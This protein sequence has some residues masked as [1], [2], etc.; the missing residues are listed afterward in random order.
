MKKILITGGAGYIGSKLTTKLLELNYQVTVVDT[1]NYTS[2][3]LNHLYNNKNFIFI[4]DDVRNKRLIKR[5]IKKNEFIIPLAALVG[6]P[7]CEENRKDAISINLDS[8]K[9]LIKNIK[10]KNK[11]IYLTTNSGYG[12]GV[13]NKYC[14]EKSPLNP[15]SLYG[16]TKVEAEKVVMQS[17]NV[18]SFRLATVFG[19]SY[20]MRT[21]LLVNDF[22]Y[23]SIKDKQLTI[24]EPNFRRNYI[25]IN[26]VVDG[27]IFSIKN[28]NKLKSNVYN[29]GLSSANL[30]KLMLAKKIK[31]QLKHLKIIIIKNK[32][33]PDQR[34]Y[35]VSNKKIEKKGFKAKIKIEDGISELINIFSNSKEKFINNY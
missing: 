10:T 13:K 21:D 32:K 24:F 5:L 30:T 19:Y 20:R 2:N 23:K 33:D 11:V 14:N 15:I 34:D 17:R 9:Y 22:V 18:V 26:D 28:F 6:A 29:L 16:K 8:I 4:N 12:I 1:L 7:L 35:F 25:H 27:I 3:S 31:K